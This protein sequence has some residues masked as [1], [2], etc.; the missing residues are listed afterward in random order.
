VARRQERA[1]LLVIGTYRPVEVLAQ[2]HPLK[3]VKQELQVHGQCEELALDFLREEHVAEYLMQRFAV[4]AIHESPLRRLTHLIHQRT[5]GN[6]L[7][8]VTVVNELVA[9][10]VLVQSEGRWELQGGI[11]ESI[12]G[13]RRVCSR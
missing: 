9:R 2:E 12:G 5:D 4:E 10:G 13:Y 8:M 1:H 6:P 7:F 3:G 11:E